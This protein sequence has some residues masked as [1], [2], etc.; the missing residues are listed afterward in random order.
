MGL[1]KEPFFLPIELKQKLSLSHNLVVTPTLQFGLT[2]LAMTQ[3][4]LSEVI[5]AELNENPALEEWLPEQDNWRDK[6]SFKAEQH[7][8]QTWQEYVFSQINQSQFNIVEREIAMRLIEGLDE[9]DE[10]KPLLSQRIMG[11]ENTLERLKILKSEITPSMSH[12]EKLIANVAN[13]LELPVS[14]VESVRRRMATCL[15]LS[16]YVPEE[17]VAAIRPDAR[18]VKAGLEFSIILNDDGLSKLKINSSYQT[19]PFMREKVRAAKWLIRCIRQRQNTLSKT[20][21]SIVKFQQAWFEERADLAPLI[22]QTVADDIG[23]HESTVSR[24]TTG[25]YVETPRGVFELKYFFHASEEKIKNLIRK[26]I[27]SENTPLSD[28]EIAL[29]LQKKGLKLARRT[30]TKYRKQ[31]GLQISSKRKHEK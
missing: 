16:D 21:S 11:K 23:M 2:L 17:Q 20:L 1:H 7:A 9:E 26:I 13:E 31:L 19:N 6:A 15:D 5:D 24:I 29:A 14:W 25:K 22:L 28:Q 8:E 30:V 27:A 4:E 12:D 3:A 10:Q 18:I